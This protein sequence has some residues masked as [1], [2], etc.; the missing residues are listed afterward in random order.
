[1]QYL[2]YGAGR[3]RTKTTKAVANPFEEVTHQASPMPIAPP[4]A[5]PPDELQGIWQFRKEDRAAKL[6]EDGRR[7]LVLLQCT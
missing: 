3:T 1:M 7:R 2:P 4:F 6:T 5:C